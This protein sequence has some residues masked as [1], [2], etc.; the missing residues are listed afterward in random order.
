M[1]S[2]IHL[3]RDLW[4]LV[5]EILPLDTISGLALSQASFDLLYHCAWDVCLRR[6]NFAE[7]NKE[8]QLNL[9]RILSKQ[10]LDTHLDTLKSLLRSMRYPLGEKLPRLSLE[11]NVDD[12][13]R[14]PD[15]DLPH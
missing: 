5:V 13:I 9:L 3:P 6:L 1:T 7:L 4:L 8:Q 10:L 11:A 12:H 2:K 14:K 15:F